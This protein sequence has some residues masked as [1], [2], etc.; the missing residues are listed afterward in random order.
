MKYQTSKQEGF[1]I[2]AIQ[3]EILSSNA[4]EFGNLIQATIDSGDINIIIDF[5]GVRL[6]DSS[7]VTIMAKYC[8][9]LQEKKGKF[10]LSGCNEI[11][12]KVFTMV[13]FNKFFKIVATLK[14]ALLEK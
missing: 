4:Q 9:I 2:L 1:I 5:A 13:G 3:E 11:T 6:I 10:I 14:E 7:G 8:R 12:K